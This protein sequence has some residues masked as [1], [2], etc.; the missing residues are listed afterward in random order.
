MLIARIS[1]ALLPE[2]DA[3]FPRLSLPLMAESLVL[4]GLDASFFWVTEAKELSVLVLSVSPTILAGLTAP[5]ESFEAM[6]LF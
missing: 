1:T 2:L 6:A 3:T 4:T 5:V